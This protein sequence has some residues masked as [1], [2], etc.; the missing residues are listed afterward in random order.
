MSE[1]LTSKQPTVK[2]TAKQQTVLPESASLML[3]LAPQALFLADAGGRLVAVGGAWEALTGVPEEDALGLPLTS[4]VALEALTP[5]AE[6]PDTDGAGVATCGPLRRRF[7]VTWRREGGWLAGSLAPLSRF[8][9]Q[10]ERQVGELEASLDATL[11]AFGSQTSRREQDHVE[12]VAH[13]AARFGEVLGLNAEQRRALHWAAY[14]H[15]VGKARVPDQILLKPAPLTDE[16]RAVIRQHPAWGEDILAGLAFLPSEVREAVLS[17]HERWD[18]L[19]YPKG[20]R[21]TQIPLLARA[22]SIAD[23]FDALTSERSYKPAWDYRD[24]AEH[25]L[26]EAGCQFDPDL[27]GMFVRDV[28]HLDVS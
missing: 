8:E 3:H 1:E 26:R 21:G 2:Q 16:E 14:L 24:A 9:W 15:D 22:L 11:R 18:G 13:Y 20:L 12:R 19:G 5:G 7:G 25:L 23:V 28:L 6:Y 10:L 27:A 17:H 4:V